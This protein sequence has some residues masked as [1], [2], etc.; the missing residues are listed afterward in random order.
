MVPKSFDLVSPLARDECVRRLRAN[1]ESWWFPFSN[2]PVAGYVE[3][4]SFRI[5]K[6]IAYVNSAQPHLSGELVDE[7]RGTRLRCR[8]GMHPAV[9]VFLAIWFGGVAIGG[10]TI[11]MR[12]IGFLLRGGALTDVWLSIATPAFML[13]FGVALVG[14]GRFSGR[15]EA[16]FLLDFLRDTIAAR[17]A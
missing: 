17:E 13:A 2:K 15:N 10:G 6:N 4:T 1:T 8:L 14:L 16:Q 5:R 12:A 7:D 9:V 11:A 3:D